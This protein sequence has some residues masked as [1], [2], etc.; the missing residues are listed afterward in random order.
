MKNL[1]LKFNKQKSIKFDLIV[2]ITLVVF[3]ACISMTSF[4]GYRLVSALN[5]QIETSIYE[6]AKN[7]ARIL[8]GEI[9]SNFRILN[10]AAGKTK[11]VI[12]QFLS[13][14]KFNILFPTQMQTNP[15]EF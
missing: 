9:Q 14:T 8:Q 4:L 2:I 1:K 5:S 10:V 7:G 12:H 6:Y 3:V 13:K 11:F 15:M